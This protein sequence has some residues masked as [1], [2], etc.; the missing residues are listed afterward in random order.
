MTTIGR[1]QKGPESLPSALGPRDAPAF[2]VLYRPIPTLIGLCR[3]TGA[4]SLAIMR[5]VVKENFSRD[6]AEALVADFIEAIEAL[7]KDHQQV[8]EIAH[9]VS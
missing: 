3:S 7:Q 2:I 9:T 5:V 8:Q 4:E 6:L 1:G